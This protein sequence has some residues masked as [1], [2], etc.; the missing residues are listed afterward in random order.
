[1]SF[2]WRNYSRDASAHEDICGLSLMR[3]IGQELTS[4]VF[5]R[6]ILNLEKAGRVV[7]SGRKPKF[8]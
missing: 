8:G 7:A 1:M 3:K 5:V 4:N 6:N 2:D